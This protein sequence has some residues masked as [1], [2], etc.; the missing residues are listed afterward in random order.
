MTK[1]K[2]NTPDENTV[3]AATSMGQLSKYAK[4]VTKVSIER[5]LWEMLRDEGVGTYQVES[6]CLQIL[7]GNKGGK[8][9]GGSRKGA[10][11]EKIEN[12]KANRDAKVVKEVLE[13]K[14]R[15]CL[16]E[17]QEARKRYSGIKSKVKEI[18][19]EKPWKIKKMMRKV[20]RGTSLA[21]EKD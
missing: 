14:V 7:K 10:S 9:G 12:L 4:E 19:R 6:Q 11:E 8:K 13:I 1:V 17:E 15:R 5:K 16:K 18:F 21:W 3:N 2:T 20:A